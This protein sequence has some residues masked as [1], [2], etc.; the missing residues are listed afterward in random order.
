MDDFHLKKFEGEKLKPP[1]RNCLTRRLRDM[2]L[3]RFFDTKFRT[4]KKS[5][6]QKLHERGRALLGDELDIVRVL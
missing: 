2:D 5:E 6:N 4:L 1:L 3:Q